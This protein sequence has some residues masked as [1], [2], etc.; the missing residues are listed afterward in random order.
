MILER[1]EDQSS[2]KTKSFGAKFE[3]PILGGD[4]FAG[5]QNRAF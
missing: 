3:W 5:S 2:A 4:E 1:P